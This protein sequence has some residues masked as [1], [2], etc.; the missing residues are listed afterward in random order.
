MFKSPPRSQ[1]GHMSA[2]EASLS[3]AGVG[4]SNLLQTKGLTVGGGGIISNRATPS[5]SIS[6]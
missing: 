1:I 6:F 5:A 3:K 2:Q 4:A